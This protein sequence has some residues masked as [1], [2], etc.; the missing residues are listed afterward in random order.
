MD[1]VIIITITAIVLIFD[2]FVWK[3]WF[4][5]FPIYLEISAML[6]ARIE[7]WP[8]GPPTVIGLIFSLI[9][10]VVSLRNFVNKMVDEK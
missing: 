10:A 5:S 8:Y 9:M 2:G 7:V 6:Y 1:A 4:L 3:N